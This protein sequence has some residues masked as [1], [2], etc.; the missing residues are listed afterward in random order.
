[1]LPLIEAFDLTKTY[2]STIALESVSFEVHEGVTGLLGRCK[3]A[4]W[5]Q[6]FRFRRKE[7]SRRAPDE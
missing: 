3:S 4:N 5:D 1:M 2:G 7:R 6:P